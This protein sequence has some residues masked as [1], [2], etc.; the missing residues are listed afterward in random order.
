M[1][2]IKIHTQARAHTLPWA[3]P[4]PCLRNAP[5]FITN[6]NENFSPLLVRTCVRSFYSRFVK[7]TLET[8]A[9]HDQHDKGDAAQSVN[10]LGSEL[11]LNWASPC[12]SCVALGELLNFSGLWFSHHWDRDNNVYF[13]QL[14]RRLEKMCL[15]C[16]L[17]CLSI[18]GSIYFSLPPSLRPSPSLCFCP[19]ELCPPQSYCYFSL[20]VPT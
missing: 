8:P 3:A 17:K 19:Q 6:P 14:R 12:T 2:T 11:G 16:I 5:F 4:G 20:Q 18:N 13:A 7:E 1:G 15:K 10:G 9:E